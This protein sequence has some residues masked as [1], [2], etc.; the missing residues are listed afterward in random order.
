[1]AWKTRKELNLQNELDGYRAK[2]AAEMNSLLAAMKNRQS[3]FAAD[4][5]Q[6]NTYHVAMLDVKMSMRQLGITVEEGKA[7]AAHA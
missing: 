4:Q 7:D 6:F 2:V 3:I 1:M 5:P